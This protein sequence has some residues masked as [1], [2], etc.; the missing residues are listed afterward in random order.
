MNSYFE[1]T[2]G[3]LNL[4]KFEFKINNYL[5]YMVKFNVIAQE[6]LKLNVIV[7]ELL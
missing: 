7:Q 3:S 1:V 5:S 4:K 6:V 2:N